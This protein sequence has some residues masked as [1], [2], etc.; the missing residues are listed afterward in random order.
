[1]VWSVSSRSVSLEISL[2][3]RITLQALEHDS[4]LA[5]DVGGLEHHG[6]IHVEVR[7]GG[8]NRTCPLAMTS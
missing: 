3:V 4:L 5:R 1:M 7:D 8:V 2:A 6:D